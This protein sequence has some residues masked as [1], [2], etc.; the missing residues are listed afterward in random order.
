MLLLCLPEPWC[1]VPVVLDGVTLAPDVAFWRSRVL[2][3]IEGDQHRTDR[4][5]WLSDLD[6]YNLVQRLGREQYRLTVSTPTRT[7]R[8]LAP[9][10]ERIRARHRPDA[11]LPRIAGF[12][13]GIPEF[14]EVRWWEG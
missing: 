7:A 3:E 1:N 13:G 2:I 9:I 8:D 12:F 4:A 5:Q 10:A 14:G 11:E 6:R